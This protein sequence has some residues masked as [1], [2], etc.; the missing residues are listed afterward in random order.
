MLAAARAAGHPRA[1]AETT[2]E[3]EA[4]LS[5]G[6]AAGAAA[7]LAR[8]TDLYDTARYHELDAG[9]PARQDAISRA[10]AVSDELARAAL[11]VSGSTP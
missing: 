9:E 7:S 5:G 2:R 11:D 10:D 6:P 8:L 1:A 4:R 3:L